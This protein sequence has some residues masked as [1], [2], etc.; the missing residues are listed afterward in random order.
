M[1]SPSCLSV[2]YQL[3]SQLVDFYDVQYGVHAIEG[4]LDAITF[5]PVASTKMADV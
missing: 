1:R 4:D 3:L 2:P 5:S